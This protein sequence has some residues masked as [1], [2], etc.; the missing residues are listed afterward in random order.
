[1]VKLKLYKIEFEGVWGVGNCLILLA[2]NE[3]HAA[4]IAKDTIKHTD[5]FEVKE[6]EMDIPKV[7][8]YLSGD[9]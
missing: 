6:V 7:V 3:A 5:K 1:M 4:E 8:M 9:Y 2:F